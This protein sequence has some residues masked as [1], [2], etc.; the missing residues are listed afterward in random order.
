MNN[1]VE[2]Y[3]MFKSNNVCNYIDILAEE[4]RVLSKIPKQLNQLIYKYYDLFV[5]SNR[6][7]DYGLLKE[8]TGLDVPNDKLILFY[9][10]IEFE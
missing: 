5:L 3:L 6:E 8:K 1:I 10:L 9:L 7:I 2:A 4:M